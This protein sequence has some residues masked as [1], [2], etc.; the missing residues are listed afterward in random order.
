M[1]Q[2]AAELKDT[3]SDTKAEI[4]TMAS[5]TRTID[6]MVGTVNLLANAYQVAEGALV[7]LGENSEEW[8]ETMVKLQAIMAVTSG[9]QEIQNL[10][11]KESAAMMFLNT[12]QTKAAAAAQGIYAFAVGASTLKMK[13]FRIAMLATGVG[14]LIAG[15]AALAGAFDSLSSSVE[16]ETEKQKK[17]TEAILKTDDAYKKIIEKSDKLRARSN[18]GVNVLNRELIILKA[19]GA[20]QLEIFNKEQEIRREELFRL[21]ASAKTRF[22]TQAEIDANLLEALDLEKE[23]KDKQTEIEAARLEFE[24]KAAD[25]SKKVVVKSGKDKIENIK[26]VAVEEVKT[27]ENKGG[28]FKRIARQTD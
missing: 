18:E 13:A 15:I 7:L 26:D 27:R 5:D 14:A 10:L 3:I 24:R 21:K 19:K 4:K 11:Q 12:V 22:Q 2:R 16:E 9:I 28:T 25:E 23:I 20:T 6:G 17:L 8:K 1:R